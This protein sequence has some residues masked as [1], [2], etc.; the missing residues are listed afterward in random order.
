M[1]GLTGKQW[2]AH[3]I[4]SSVGALDGAPEGDTDVESGNEEGGA[5][6][7]VEMSAWR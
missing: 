7:H 1:D 5:D 4:D 6:E 3:T 2:V